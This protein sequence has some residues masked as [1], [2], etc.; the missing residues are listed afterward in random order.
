MQGFLNLAS[1]AGLA[2]AL[3]LSRVLAGPAAADEAKSVQDVIGG[4]EFRISCSSCHGLTGKGDGAVAEFLKVKPTDLTQIAKKN[5][6]VFPIADIEKVV[7][8]RGGARV[9]GS[10]MPVWGNRYSAESTESY[11]AF[12]G[13]M[14]LRAR[15]LSLVF[16]L[17]SIQ[18]QP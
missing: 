12:V 18:Q 9:H 8:G 11:G 15:I 3:G 14:V 5:G 10:E 17:Q 2:L 6:G 4:D 13:E 16:Y 7:D 1:A